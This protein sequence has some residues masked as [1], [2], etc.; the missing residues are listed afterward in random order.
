MVI[1]GKMNFFFSTLR[2]TFW[3]ALYMG[4]KLEREGET[5]EYNGHAMENAI[6][7]TWFFLTQIG[8]GTAQQ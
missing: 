3:H 4:M 7:G 5:S 8:D 6:Q 1:T 2:Y